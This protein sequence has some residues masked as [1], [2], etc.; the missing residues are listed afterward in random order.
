VVF[1][2]VFIG[3]GEA[4]GVAGFAFTDGLSLP[5]P[6]PP[7]P[8]SSNLIFFPANSEIPVCFLLAA[9]EGWRLGSDK[10]SF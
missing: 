10:L 4:K 1:V 5:A 6:P 9:H 7:P 2:T 3:L 8:S